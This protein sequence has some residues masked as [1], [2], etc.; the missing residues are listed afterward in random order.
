M[1]SMAPYSNKNSLS[2][3]TSNSGIQANNRSRIKPQADSQFIQQMGASEQEDMIVNINDF[4]GINDVI[5][6][7]GN[8]SRER[9]Y[10]N[11]YVL[12]RSE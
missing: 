3:A 10:V 11:S 1:G 7:D 6:T 2:Q 9:R 8:L 5:D 4:D 12:P